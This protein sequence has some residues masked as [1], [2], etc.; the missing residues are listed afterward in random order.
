[1]FDVVESIIW[2]RKYIY[3]EKVNKVNRKNNLIFFKSKGWYIL[4]FLTQYR[5]VESHMKS[6]YEVSNQKVISV[7]FLRV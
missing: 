6:F 1:M 2:I 4:L 3:L 5:A 7:F